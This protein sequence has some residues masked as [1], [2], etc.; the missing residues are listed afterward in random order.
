MTARK[1]RMVRHAE[2]VAADE[3]AATAQARADRAIASLR[4]LVRQ[5][6]RIGGYATHEDQAEVREARAVIA[7]VGG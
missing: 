2:L 1:P 5:L 7:E 6:E 3:R 4:A